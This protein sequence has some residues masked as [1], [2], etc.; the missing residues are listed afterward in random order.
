[1]T[2]QPQFFAFISPD[3][4]IAG[5]ARRVGEQAALYGTALAILD[6]PCNLDDWKRF[7]MEEVSITE[8]TERL[9]LAHGGS[10]LRVTVPLREPCWLCAPAVV[11]EA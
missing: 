9:L 11:G 6:A 7:L 1:M 5:L 2:D 4:L 10:K 3:G 8:A